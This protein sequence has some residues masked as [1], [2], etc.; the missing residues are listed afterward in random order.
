MFRRC[1]L[2]AAATE[3]KEVTK[4][5]KEKEKE[6]YRC[7][8]SDYEYEYDWETLRD[9][10]DADVVWES[11]SLSA[12]TLQDLS[13]KTDRTRRS[14][15]TAM[16]YS[17]PKETS[18]DT[19]INDTITI[20][21]GASDTALL[22]IAER[23]PSVLGQQDE[24]SGRFPV[25]MA[26]ACGA[27]PE[28]VAKCVSMFPCTAAAQDRDGK[29]PFH[30]LCESYAKGCDTSMTRDV[31]EKRM[32]NI[33]WILYRKAPNAITLEDNHGVDAVEYALESDSSLSF[34]RLLQMMVAR[35]HE[36]NAK[37]KANRKFMRV[38]RQRREESH[39]AARV[40]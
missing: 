8:N 6:G 36:G 27:S 34:L 18:S 22:H 7:Q 25:H 33:L 3:P 14:L 9:V 11:L 29:N 35:V 40:A 20:I 12:M 5:K 23:I 21:K 15:I 28:F 38:S 1:N 19:L 31:I 37:K 26:C 10:V 30:I 24:L 32:T 4:T 39:G 16:L 13:T 2:T 17:S